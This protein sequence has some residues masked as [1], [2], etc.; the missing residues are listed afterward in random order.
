[1]DE[2]KVDSRYSP[3]EKTVPGLRRRDFFKL[4]G[5]GLYIFFNVGA[6]FDVLAGDSEGEQFRRLPSDYNAFLLV[7]EDGTVSCF[8]GKIEM[9]QGIITSLG[10]MLADE[11]DV[12]FEKVK[13]VMGDTRLCPYD[14]G[15]FGSMSTRVFGPSLRAAAAEA[16]GVLLELGAEKL[17]L[18]AGQLDVKDGVIFSKSNPSRKVSYQELTKGKKIEKHLDKQP[19]VKDYSEFKIMGKSFNRVDGQSKVTGEAKYSGDMRVPGMVYARILRPP[20]HGAK[21]TSVDTSEAEK[22]PGVKI[23]HD[24]DLVAALHE[25]PEEAAKARDKMKAQ[26][27]FDEMD[28][29]DKTIFDHLLKVAGSGNVVNNKG[30]IDA[31]RKQSAH[32][33]ESEYLDGYKAH[34]PIEPHTALAHIEGDNITLWVSTQTPFPAQQTISRELGFPMENVRIIPPFLGGGFGGKSPH[35]QAVEAARLA[36]LSGK[37][38]MVDWNREEEFFYDTF[39]PAAI[40]KITSGIDSNGKI[41]LWD[42]HEYYAGTRG[43]DTVYEVP[44]QRTTSYG[45]GRFESENS[46]MSRAHPFATGAWRAPGNSTN[47]FG[48]ESQIDIMAAKAGM[49]PLEFRLKNLTDERMIPVLN[50]VAKKFG[51]TPAKS[52]S[53]RGFGIAC[54]FDAG[55]YVAHMVEVK[56][57][58]QTGEVQVVRIACAQEMGYCINPEGATIQME[59]CINMGLGYA[60]KEDIKFTGGKLETTNFDS[61]DIP[62]F[63]WVPK[64][65]T[66]ILEKNAPPQGGG[67]PAIICMG[68]VIANAIFDATGARLYQLP[69]IP[70]RVLAAIKKV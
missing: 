51:W 10:M 67:E 13:M 54:G 12:A 60:L 29:N 43:S 42:Y 59:G 62:R 57:N 52:P 47:T 3:E 31:G 64:I 19:E 49:D 6:A 66:T 5:G 15:T 16:R 8:T 37:P 17:G 48:R 40:I 53:G 30:D 65:E 20:S 39:R 9:G 22:V 28:V 21:L 34:S 4:L 27:S 61:Y 18:P 50:A 11:L 35:N 46:S 33:F 24:G 63:S 56:V 45:G 32:I 69:M 23:I 41:T 14:M 2:L 70:E 26:Y 25:D 7:H 36:K 38:V 68:A 1:M 44:N 55:S 58:K